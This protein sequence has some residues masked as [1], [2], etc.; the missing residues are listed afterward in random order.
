MITFATVLRRCPKS[1]RYLL[2]LEFL[3]S[4]FTP[5]KLGSFVTQAEALW[6]KYV[7]TVILQGAEATTF[8][9][10]VRELSCEAKKLLADQVRTLVLSHP[11]LRNLFLHEV[12]F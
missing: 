3:S 4:S 5:L 12:I 7:A 8:P 1:K 11:D 2:K 9:S 10:I 6:A